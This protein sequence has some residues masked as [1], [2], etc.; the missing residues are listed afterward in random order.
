MYSIFYTLYNSLRY[1]KL[2]TLHVFCIQHF[3]Y[4][5]NYL[6]S[7]LDA[8]NSI[9]VRAILI[10]KT[11]L[12]KKDP[13]VNNIS[14]CFKRIILRTLYQTLQ[15]YRR[16]TYQ[17]FHIADCIPIGTTRC[18]KT[19]IPR[20]VLHSAIACTLHPIQTTIVL[21]ITYCKFTTYCKFITY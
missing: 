20:K 17:Y 21:F 6:S 3:R 19:I 10:T 9:S 16:T 14:K 15:V 11:I 7:V 18:I 8:A 2:S 5:T 12:Y 1:F 13:T 4:R